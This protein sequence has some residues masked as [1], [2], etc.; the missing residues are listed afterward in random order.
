MNVPPLEID[1]AEVVLWTVLDER[2]K[3]TGNTKHYRDGELQANFSGLAIAK[4]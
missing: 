2:H 4:V 1:N 3:A